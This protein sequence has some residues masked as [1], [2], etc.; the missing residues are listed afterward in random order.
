MVGQRQLSVR[1]SAFSCPGF[2]K[3]PNG[4]FWV[5]VAL[6]C[7]EIPRQP[8]SQGREW[9]NH[10]AAEVTDGNRG[11]RRGM[12][13]LEDNGTTR[14]DTAPRH[15]LRAFLSSNRWLQLSSPIST[16][17]SEVTATWIAGERN[18]GVGGG[19]RRALEKEKK[20]T[21]VRAPRR[22]LPGDTTRSEYATTSRSVHPMST[23]R[24]NAPSRPSRPRGSRGQSSR[25]PE[26]LGN[27][28]PSQAR[29]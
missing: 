18:V 29:A 27:R 28:G 12:G 24:G 16:V 26:R 23:G 10:T 3:S 25:L 2:R 19:A 11:Q 6:P 9:K 20:R 5:S 4:Q 17:A 15:L 14:I 21:H 13:A 8:T 22:L 1:Q 7:R